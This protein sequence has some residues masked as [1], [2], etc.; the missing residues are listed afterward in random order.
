MIN[1]EG[2][3]KIPF[4]T[5]TAA[6]A[7]LGRLSRQGS[8]VESGHSA[9]VHIHTPECCSYGHPTPAPRLRV[10]PTGEQAEC[11]F[12]CCSLHEEGGRIQPSRH[13]A[14][15]H[16][17]VHHTKKQSQQLLQ[18]APHQEPHHSA[19]TSSRYLL[20][21]SPSVPRRHQHIQPK[22]KIEKLPKEQ[23]HKPPLSPRH[24]SE[25]QFSDP[26]TQ[27]KQK[28][29]VYFQQKQ[30]LQQLQ[31]QLQQQQLELQQMQGQ[32]QQ[33]MQSKPRNGCR[34]HDHPCNCC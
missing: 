10:S 18:V 11:D 7:Y 6:G 22:I 5:G 9:T 12:H 26:S 32:Q 17:Q 27:V 2:D 20:P 3:H 31:Q 28:Q 25:S 29:Q 1:H 33:Q 15:Q 14:Q 23:H 19:T 16:H 13:Y 8:S 21:P 34:L 4:G 24:S 30:H